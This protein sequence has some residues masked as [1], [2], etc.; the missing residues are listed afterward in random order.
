MR[1]V[2][3]LMMLALAGCTQLA[4]PTDH[5][6]TCDVQAPLE[7]GIRLTILEAEEVQGRCLQAYNVADVQL[8]RGGHDV[9]GQVLLEVPSDGIVWVP[10]G[11]AG[12]YMVRV[13]INDW[14]DGDCVYE[15]AAS[16]D[17]QAGVVEETLRKNRSCA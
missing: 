17:W 6:W 2:A 8:E 7:A 9:P 4:D 16:I 10:T 12:R 3:V 15:W 13:A 5:G 1:L 11:D 14:D